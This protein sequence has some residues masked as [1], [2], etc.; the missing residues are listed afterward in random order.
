MVITIKV[1]K[2]NPWKIND[3]KITWLKTENKQLFNGGK[4]KKN[5]LNDIIVGIKEKIINR[6]NDKI[7]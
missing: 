7:V 6:I 5:L 1:L 2:K 4:R 3:K